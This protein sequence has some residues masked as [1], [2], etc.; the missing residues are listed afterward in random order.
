[1]NPTNRPVLENGPRLSCPAPSGGKG[2]VLGARVLSGLKGSQVGR[3]LAETLLIAL[4]YVAV[5]RFGSAFVTPGEMLVI[6]PSGI[7]LAAPLVLGARALPGVMIGALLQGWWTVGDP[8]VVS[9]LALAETMEGAIGAWLVVRFARGQE[10]YKRPRDILVFALLAG[11][12]SP[13]MCP[14]FGIPEP[15]LRSLGFWTFKPDTVL[16]WWLGEMVSV[17]TFAPLA[18][19]WRAKPVRCWVEGRG[20]ELLL[21]LALTGITNAVV[22]SNLVPFPIRRF[23]MPYLC[24]PFPIWAAHRFGATATALTTLVNGFVAISG[25]L[26]GRAGSMGSAADISLTTYQ[27]STSFFS[28]LGL[29]V[30]AVVEQ[31]AQAQTALKVAHDDLDRR[32]AERTEALHGEIEVRRKAEEQL[33]RD[34]VW[35]RQ[36]ERELKQAHDELDRRV[37]ERTGELA[38]ANESLELE[39]EQRR[40]TE[41]VL[42]QVLQRLIDVQETERQRISRE[43][44]D[45]MGQTLTALKLGLSMACGSGGCPG[46]VRENLARLESLSDE[47]ARDMH[48]M[49]W[50]LRPP[51]LDEQ[52]LAQALRHYTSEWSRRAGIPVDFHNGI[53]EG[54]RLPARLET[55]LYRIAQES[56]NNILKHARA[57]RVSVLLDRNIEGISMIIEDDGVGFDTSGDQRI[58]SPQGKLGLLGMQ[59]RVLLAGG[60]M[61][62]ESAPDAGTTIFV[63]IP[64]PIPAPEVHA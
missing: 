31:R 36:A 3:R 34:I 33:S 19:L 4:A 48:R 41:E 63:R 21:L 26:M 50:E 27:G 14:P 58:A 9:V 6:P 29:M 2:G 13:L 28:V 5:G 20:G 38:K 59:E 35:R 40:R 17:F 24:L 57:G 56:M 52:G 15:S 44:H 7:A 39:V 51:A 23:L 11:V 43:L 18:V 30:A 47:L 49:A 64:I 16:A 8:V 42:S 60:T 62:I 61:S 12:L 22:F 54:H 25:V 45:Q 53:G 55:T 46:P 1:M 37:Q 32:V 10:F